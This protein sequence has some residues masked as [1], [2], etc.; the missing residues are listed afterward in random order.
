MPNPASRPPMLHRKYIRLNCSTSSGLMRFMKTEFQQTPAKHKSN[1]TYPP[2]LP[3]FF[4]IANPYG[5][6]VKEPVI[7][8]QAL[9]TILPSGVIYFIYLT[10]GMKSPKGQKP[11]AVS[12]MLPTSDEHVDPS[13]FLITSSN[14]WSGSGIGPFTVSLRVSRVRLVD[15]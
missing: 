7:M 12:K 4:P 6:L 1:N 2:R 5:I 10:I 11:V 8:G 15:P 13:V 14:Y 9:I 3:P